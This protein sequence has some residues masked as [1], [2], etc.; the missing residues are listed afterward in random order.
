MKNIKLNIMLKNVRYY[1]T[2]IVLMSTHLFA[3]NTNPVVSNVAFSI[4]GTTVTVTY[5]VTDAQQTTVTIG[6]VVSSDNGA[7]WNFNFGSAN[8]DIGTGVSIGNSKTITWNYSGGYNPNFMIRI[9]ANDE[10]ADGNNCGNLYYEGGPHIDSGGAYYSTI[11]IGTQCWM[12]EN[13]NIGTMIAG[14]VNQTNNSTI[15]KY[16]FG[17]LSASCRSLDSGGLGYGGLYQWNEAMQY[18]TTS[19][20]QG[21]CPIGWHIP[22]I[23][24]FETLSKAVGGDG[25]ALKKIGL[26]SANDGAGTNTSGFSALFSGFRRSNGTY[27]EGE[28]SFYSWISAEPGEPYP[29]FAYYRR[30]DYNSSTFF[31][32]QNFKDF[33]LSVRCLKN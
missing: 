27:T 31:F 30:L 33:G 8:G 15:E 32:I 21:I 29:T 13:L 20:T 1:I 23:E 17:D 3:Q 19:G 2:F 16:C 10:T 5:D 4:S 7:T 26:N 12:K 11:E 24:E 28:N 18:V 22:T 6:M 9:I 25:N 14:S